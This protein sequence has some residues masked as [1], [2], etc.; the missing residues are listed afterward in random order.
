MLKIMSTKSSKK[1]KGF[2][3]EVLR[4]VKQIFARIEACLLYKKLFSSAS[5]FYIL[6]LV[7]K[8]DFISD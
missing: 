1:M 3:I 4:L 5:A 6:K 2:H 7:Q 8:Q